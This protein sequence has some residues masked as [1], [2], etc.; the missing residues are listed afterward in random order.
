[1]DF[2]QY[3]ENVINNEPKTH[4]A[5]GK[6][7][8]HFAMCCYFKSGEKPKFTYR[9][10]QTLQIFKAGKYNNLTNE[11]EALLLKYQL[12]QS[13]IKS[14]KIWNNKNSQL[15]QLIFDQN[16]FGQINVDKIGF[17]LSKL[18]QNNDKNKTR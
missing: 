11:L 14:C 10:D 15:E 12:I 1:M 16:E 4:T 5:S 17:E 7:V 18:R 6:P 8:S 9:G 3:L 2:R 13:N